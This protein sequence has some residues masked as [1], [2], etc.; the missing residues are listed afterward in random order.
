MNKS[1]CYVGNTL[2][3]LGFWFSVLL[4]QALAQTI[5]AA[6]QGDNAIWH[7][8]TTIS[9]SQAFIDAS[10]WCNGDCQGVD[11][12]TMV[13]E[14]L[15]TLPTQGGVVDA[16]GLVYPNDGNETCTVNPFA[17]ITVPSTVLLPR[18]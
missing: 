15:V 16:R 12:C 7:S 10:A 8:S 9:G 11:F 13:N 3:L 2:V 1:V 14:A 5:N 18:Q 6:P 17:G 4:T